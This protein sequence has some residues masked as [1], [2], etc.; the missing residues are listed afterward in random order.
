MIEEQLGIKI[1]N[2]RNIN[3]LTQDELISRMELTIT[4]GYISQQ[5]LE[6]LTLLLK[7]IYK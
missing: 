4:K 3:G 2:L 1:R 6:V 5:I 7:Q